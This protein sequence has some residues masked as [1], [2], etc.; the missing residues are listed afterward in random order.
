MSA[1][2]TGLLVCDLDGTLLGDDAAT[3][4]FRAAWAAAVAGDVRL[5]YATGRGYESYVGLVEDGI[6][7]APHA[8]ITSTGA[9]IRATGDPGLGAEWAAA[10]AAVWQQEA[11]LEAVGGFGFPVLECTPLRLVLG[12]P[13]G[14]SSDALHVRVDDMRAALTRT[15]A[16][17]PELIISSHHDGTFLDIM[18]PGI[19][20][21]SAVAFIQ[22]HFGVEDA[23]TVVAGDS[24][25]DWAMLR[26]PGR[27]GVVVANANA[28]LLALCRT[29]PAGH[30]EM[31]YAKAACAAGVIEG[32][33]H[34][35]IFPA[36][37]G[38]AA[39]A[40]EGGPPCAAEP[41]MVPS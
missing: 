25:N 41:V 36:G 8:S 21:G 16:H 23:R 37:S 27:K 28:D 7:P 29:L 19:D 20:K 22:K 30:N 9:D 14:A 26:L 32:L 18:P 5:V 3:A 35:G 17:P 40:P 31:Y 13:E 38:E 12:L 4:R 24:E 15:C 6:L 11:A 10:V 33:R 1:P 39:P 2:G 34:H